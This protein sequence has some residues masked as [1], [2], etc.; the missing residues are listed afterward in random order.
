[1]FCLLIVEMKVLGTAYSKTTYLLDVETLSI[2]ILMNIS[3]LI[4][5]ETQ[6]TSV[7]SVGPVAAN[8]RGHFRL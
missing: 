3:L 5:L 4:V 7:S 8:N 2:R 6:L 1:M